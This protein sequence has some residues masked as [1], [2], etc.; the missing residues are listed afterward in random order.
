LTQAFV[1]LINARDV[2]DL[3]EALT[4]NRV[5]LG[6]EAA[7]IVFQVAAKGD[8]V[9][10]D[11]ILWAGRELGDLAVGVIRQLKLEA[12]VFDV[13]LGGSFFN[14][15][16]ALAETMSEVIQGVAPGA[17]LVRLHA[18]PAVGAV[19]LG[20]ETVGAPVSEARETLISSIDELIA[21]A[22]QK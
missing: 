11:L 17:C 10:R 21:Q 8:P 16:P 4:L 20:M 14:G 18:P 9:A 7:P 2:A 1:K 19:L 6:P 12:Q 5:Q 3:L 15:S 13:V 22:H